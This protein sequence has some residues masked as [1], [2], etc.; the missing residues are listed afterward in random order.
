MFL[1]FWWQFLR[2]KM[3]KHENEMKKG[4]ELYMIQ[5]ISAYLQSIFT[6]LTIDFFLDIFFVEKRK[7]ENFKEV[8]KIVNRE[9]V[10]FSL[11][12]SLKCK[13]FFKYN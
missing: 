8:G 9:E 6:K 12:Y 11:Q 2:K 10:F 13:I 1:C 4:N 7:E 3:R 5:K